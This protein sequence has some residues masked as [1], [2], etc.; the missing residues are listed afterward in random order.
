MPVVPASA[1][2][3]TNTIRLLSKS[4]AVALDRQFT[5]A[6]NASLML[7]VIESHALFNPDVGNLSWLAGLRTGVAMKTGSQ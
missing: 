6:V 1:L 5:T 7:L 2:R 3:N 4:E